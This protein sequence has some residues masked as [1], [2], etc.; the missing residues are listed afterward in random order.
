[1]AARAIGFQDAN[2]RHRNAWC[3]SKLEGLHLRWVPY[4]MPRL[5]PNLADAVF[6]LYA[7]DP[8]K[9][10]T[11]DDLLGPRGTGVIVGIYDRSRPA[12]V[13]HYY[14]ITAAHVARGGASIIK[15]N[16]KGGASRVIDFDPCEWT[17]DL[18]WEDLAAVDITDRLRNDDRTS[19]IPLDMLATRDFNSRVQLGIGEDGFML[20]L[21]VE[22][23]GTAKNLVAARFGNVSMLADDG[24]PIS[25]H[26]PALDV[27]F[28]S[29]CHV[30]DMHS[31]PGFSGSP[32]FVYRTPDGDLTDLE[33]RVRRFRL[34]SP[35]G[36]MLLNFNPSD[37][38]EVTEVTER[39]PVFL[40]L[41]GIHVAQFQDKVTLEKV[42]PRTDEEA[43]PELRSGDT[44][45]FPGSMTIIVPAW[46]ILTLLERP[47]LKEQRQAR[48]EAANAAALADQKRGSVVQE[49]QNEIPVAQTDENPRHKE[50]FSRLVSE[51]AKKPRLA[52]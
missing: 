43:E 22:H 8:S 16:S 32:V 27:Q 2:F 50:D 26:D 9:P 28:V 44:V 31:R 34:P 25:R 45:R 17:A 41:F 38:I 18:A 24:A 35:Y 15:L 47:E 33:R 6:F 39:G 23:F 52:D 49:S 13:L 29:P 7:K 40:K 30:F 48:K 4:G 21:F 14:A 46:Q 5:S 11:S 12:S 3:W 42:T 1:M 19:Y 37:P 10:P 51:A 36:R 20:G